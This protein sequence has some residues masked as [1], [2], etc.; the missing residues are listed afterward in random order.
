[1]YGFATFMAYNRPGLAMPRV[2][3]FLDS[4]RR[5]EAAA[6]PIGCAGFCWGGKIVLLLAGEDA[7]AAGKPLMDVGFTAH[8]SFLKLPHEVDEAR[9]PVS[10]AVGDHDA[11]M[12]VPQ[13]EQAR[14]ILEAKPDGQ[15]GEVKIYWGY[16]HGF[17]LSS[18]PAQP[19]VHAHALSLPPSTTLPPL[20]LALPLSLPSPRHHR[21]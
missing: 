11:Q 7:K 10:I 1:M 19:L 4:L 8:P 5:N 21:Q 14:R 16:G 9:V 18:S 3:A 2:R 6:L 13:A 20:P 12:S 15:K 17:G